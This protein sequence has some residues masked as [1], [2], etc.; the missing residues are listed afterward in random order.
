MRKLSAVISAIFFFA[1]LLV[2]GGDAFAGK[3]PEGWTSL[4]EDLLISRNSMTYVSGD[5][6]RLWVRIVP[7]KE[8]ALYA[9]IE[10]QLLKEK[11]RKLPV[12]AYE[13]TGFLSEIDCSG[14]RHRD[15]M[16]IHYDSNRNIMQ[17]TDHSSAQWD[18]I[19][20]ES[21]FHLVETAVCSQ[22]RDIAASLR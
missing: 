4:R 16:T 7:D 5:T 6:V 9:E 1:I 10:K 3:D 12:Y 13:Y 17:W 18:K 15:L 11:G 20:P 14:K 21:R 19:S 22:D 2:A 8:S